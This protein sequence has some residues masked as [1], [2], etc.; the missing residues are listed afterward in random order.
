[1]KLFLFTFLLSVLITKFVDCKKCECG[2]N[3]GSNNGRIFNGQDAEENRHPW[4]IFIE[5][6]LL[7][8]NVKVLKDSDFGGVLISKRHVLT[9]QHGFVRD[10]EGNINEKYSY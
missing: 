10:S 2:I 7:D 1:M 8:E 5:I 4:N 6:T 3:Q 9:C